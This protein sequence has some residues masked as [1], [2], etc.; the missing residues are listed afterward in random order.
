MFLTGTIK[1][2]L[3]LAFFFPANGFKWNNILFWNCLS[4]RDAVWKQKMHK[5]YLALLRGEKFSPNM[6]KT[7]VMGRNAMDFACFLLVWKGPVLFTAFSISCFRSRIP[8]LWGHQSLSHCTSGFVLKD[9]LSLKNEHVSHA[10]YHYPFT[11][12]V[13]LENP[14]QKRLRLFYFESQT[15]C[16]SFRALYNRA[17]LQ[18]TFKAQ[19]V[20]FHCVWLQCTLLHG[21]YGLLACKAARKNPNE[22]HH[23]SVLPIPMMDMERTN[24]LCFFVFFQQQ[25][26]FVWKTWGKRCADTNIPA[27][28]NLQKKKAFWWG[29]QRGIWMCW[30]SQSSP[31]SGMIWEYFCHCKRRFRVLCP[32]FLQTRTQKTAV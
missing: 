3:H 10:A 25:R 8:F 31:C 7:P 23:T 20:I 27:T 1:F 4:E 5:I 17:R 15:S 28:R 12:D 6:P 22:M 2:M 9:P 16:L 24:H 19:N 21:P 29:N 14:F 11:L 30:K 18:V 32:T 13:S 26:S